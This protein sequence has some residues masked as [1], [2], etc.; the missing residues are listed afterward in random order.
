[1][2]EAF[3]WQFARAPQAIPHKMIGLYSKLRIAAWERFVT[4]FDPILASL[5]KTGAV[6][7]GS[8]NLRLPS[9][10]NS[11]NQACIGLGC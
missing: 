9:I 4:E 8:R 7:N 6:K 2:R 3:F 10:S 1:M 11:T 5:G